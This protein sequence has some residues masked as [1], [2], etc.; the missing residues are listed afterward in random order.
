MKR[1]V[2]ATISSVLIAGSAHAQ[3]Y[4]GA[5][6][7]YPYAAPQT[8]LPP[9]G[10]N[11]YVDSMETLYPQ[12]VIVR[13]RVVVPQPPVVIETPPAV[14]VQQPPAVVYRDRIIVRDRVVVKRRVVYKKVPVPVPVAAPTTV[15]VNVC[16]QSVNTGEVCKQQ[17]K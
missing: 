15:N 11:P 7:G 6:P 1:I 8:A 13:R 10:Y 14:I 2:I 5:G 9:P 3:Y 12:Q 17:K 4:P 16:T